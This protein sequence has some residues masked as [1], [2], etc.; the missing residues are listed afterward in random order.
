MVARGDLGVEI[1]AADVPLAQKRIIRLGRSRGQAR[2]HGDA[3]AGVDDQPARPTRAEAS[4]VANAILD[5]TARGDALGRDGGRP[6]PV[7]AVQTMVRIALAVEPS[8]TTTR[9]ATA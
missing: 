4:D 3:D 1:G 6:V 5:G 9:S 8:L 2:D 7:E